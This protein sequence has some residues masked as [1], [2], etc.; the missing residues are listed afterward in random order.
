[1]LAPPSRFSV[2]PHP[3]ST[4]EI[5][6][7]T[8]PLV[9]MAGS[10]LVIAC[11]NLANMF[12]ARAATRTREIAVRF[13]LGA[14]RWRVMRQLLTEGLLLAL[15]GGLLGLGVS[16]WGN[17]AL[18]SSLS[19][20]LRTVEDAA[21]NL[22][23]GLEPAVLLFTLG[24]CTASALLFGLVPA[25]RAC[26]RDVVTDLKAQGGES[27]DRWNRFFAGRHLLVMAQIALS[28]MLLFSA[29]LFLRAALEARHIALGFSIER[30]LI[31]KLDY[32]LRA[33]DHAATRRSLDAVRA[34]AAALPGV[35]R[36]AFSTQ[37]P[38]SSGENAYH[39][40][41]AGSPPDAETVPAL[42]SG[43]SDGYF[44][45]LD[46]PVLAGREFSPVESGNPA[47][48]PVAII[49]ASLARRLIPAGDA[50]GQRLRFAVPR[51]ANA[52]EFEIVGIIGEHRQEFLDRA[53]D[54]RIYL[55][56]SRTLGGE[57][58][59]HTTL[60][61]AT[62][63]VSAIEPVRA[64]LLAADPDLPLLGHE[65]MET[66]AKGEAS[67][68]SAQFAALVS[69]VF[70]TVALLLAILGVYAVK[71][72]AVIRRTREIGIRAALGARPRQ[73]IALIL[74]QAAQ[75][76]S[77]AIAVG[78]VL[79]LL[80]GQALSSLVYHVSPADP[81]ALGGA[82][83]VLT[84]AALAASFV[85]ARRASRVDPMIVLRAE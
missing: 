20:A 83:I 82:V 13:A 26:R 33:A 81:I 29:G 5:Y 76:V 12:L 57:V 37:P 14:T 75:Q 52:G 3:S 42:F 36:V 69:G 30:S 11:L 66:F 17:H 35:E 18:V 79:A 4:A 39:V 85:P 61:H 54:Y 55:P 47:A 48:P 44:A 2:S 41:L 58:F 21:I 53:P 50:L 59:I 7:L 46:I 45:A 67:L 6:L 40:A 68:W 16:V 51:G 31:S 80:A 32:S 23:P 63:V 15:G 84:C 56:L 10:V 38:L 19:A 64:A 65:P 49:D 28:I 34:E 24:A 71:S 77:L 43:A 22:R 78:V 27:A 1:M 8:A 25:L 73:L 60:R 74:V 72:H 9:F 70:G 62:A